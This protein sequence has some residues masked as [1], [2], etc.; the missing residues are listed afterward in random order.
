MHI[1]DGIYGFCWNLSNLLKSQRTLGNLIMVEK[2]KGSS[3][4]NQ[5]SKQTRKQQAGHLWPA[6]DLCPQGHSPQ[7]SN[8]TQRRCNTMQRNEMQCN[9]MQSKGK[10]NAMLQC[11]NATQCN[12]M[13]D[14][15]QCDAM[16]CNALQCKCKCKC[17]C[18]AMQ[19]NAM[20]CNAMRCDAMRC[21]AMQRNA[22]HAM[23]CK[24]MQYNAMQG[25]V[26]QCDAMQCFQCHAAIE[27]C[28]AMLQCNALVQ[29]GH[30]VGHRWPTSE[31]WVAMQSNAIQF[32]A[33]GNSMQY[34]AM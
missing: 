1:I 13:Q 21:N 32:K 23:Q 14:A 29:V 6:C 11:S 15:K 10:W 33:T 22:M 25:N 27:C 9:L 20:H 8:A 16:Q 12:A 7:C 24:A 17:K 19:C 28:M 2:F 3:Q 4:Q 5:T 30:Q 18:N 31:L 26:M 34:N